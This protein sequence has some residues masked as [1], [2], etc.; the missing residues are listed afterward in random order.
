MLRAVFAARLDPAG[1]PTGCSS[2]MA[3]Y[4][5]QTSG[6]AGCLILASEKAIQQFGLTPLVRFV[7]F[8]S[9]D[10]PLELMGI[11]PNKAN[12]AALKNAGLSWV[13]MG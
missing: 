1:K 12:P 9:R 10:V 13:D 3:G 6:G 4:S 8:A 11:G 2:L 7:H 5:S